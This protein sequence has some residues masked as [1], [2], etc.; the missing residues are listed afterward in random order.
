MQET[1]PSRAVCVM[2][3]SPRTLIR[4]EGLE[5]MRD[6]VIT[7]VH[8]YESVKNVYLKA[9]D[10]LVIKYDVGHDYVY[11]SEV[12]VTMRLNLVTP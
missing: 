7:S 8:R 1:N 11:I 4:R 10:T 9:Y 12:C 6:G 3:C 2:L 5:N